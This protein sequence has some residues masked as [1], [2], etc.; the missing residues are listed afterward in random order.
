MFCGKYP[1]CE[2]ET[3]IDGIKIIRKGGQYSLYL[4]APIYYLL[5]LR[6]KYDIIIDC[7]NGIPFFTP[8]FSKKKKICV[9]HHVHTDVFDKEFIEKNGIKGRKTI[10]TIGFFIIVY[11]ITRI[12]NRIIVLGKRYFWNGNANV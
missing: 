1:G 9:M 10:L 12:P 8:L 5:K 2:E 11:L 4:Y 3:V 7:E 6:K